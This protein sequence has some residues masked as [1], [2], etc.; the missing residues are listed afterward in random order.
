MPFVF[1]QATGARTRIMTDS[2]ADSLSGIKKARPEAEGKSVEHFCMI[3]CLP[4]T[5]TFAV[6]TLCCALPCV[7]VN[8][9]VL[10]GGA[11]TRD[12]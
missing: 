8:L 5:R 2:L 3:L 1:V 7:R 11:W 6:G 12:Q 4:S 10:S 9:P